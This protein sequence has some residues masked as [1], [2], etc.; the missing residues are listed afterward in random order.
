MPTEDPGQTQTR[1]K[2]RWVGK[3]R[4]SK[5]GPKPGTRHF[6]PGDTSWKPLGERSVLTKRAKTKL[7]SQRAEA[8]WLANHFQLEGAS[9]GRREATKH[10]SMSGRKNRITRLTAFPRMPDYELQEFQRLIGAYGLP[11]AQLDSDT[12]AFVVRRVMLDYFKLGILR[13]AIKPP[14][15]T[16]AELLELLHAMHLT[17]QELGRLTNPGNPSGGFA[18]LTRWLNEASKPTGIHAVRVNRL[19][20]QH[21]RRAK[22]LP[23]GMARD[24]TE[25]RAIRRARAKPERYVE[26]PQ[27]SASLK[28]REAGED[29][30]TDGAPHGA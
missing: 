30:E 16:S 23:E 19:I 3:N 12:A 18:N 1:R 9:L 21:V 6:V 29:S 25:G 20:E 10:L 26:A 7:E 5:P 13:R 4:E 14:M 28:A 15:F 2:T 11:I 8:E 22:K 17:P 24:N 27:S